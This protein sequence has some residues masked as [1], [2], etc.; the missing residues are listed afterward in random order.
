[1]PALFIGH[2]SPMNGIEVNRFSLAWQ[3]L[4]KTLPR[5]SAV[6]AIS[7]HWLTKGTH[8]HA[9]EC[10]RTI[11]D[12]WGF[13]KELYNISYP[14]PGSP[15]YANATRTL[16]APTT[17]IE[18][19]LEW[20]IDHGTWIVVRRMFPEGDIPVFQLSIDIEKPSQYHFDLGK[21]LASLR[22]KGV[23]IMGSGNL[24]HNLGRV[25][26]EPNAVSY[27]WAL[28]FDARMTDLMEKGDFSSLISY[29]KFGESAKLS[30]PSPDHYWPLLYVLG[31]KQ[32]KDT[33]SF[34]IEGITMG[35]IGMR[36]VLCK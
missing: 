30:V 36:A 1:M 35:S 20:G 7:A 24:V 19:D 25:S 9:S 29:E 8:V 4:G 10:P 12:F 14:C 6:L 28:E 13:P 2:G 5:P 15:T 32:S 33:L 16:L 31:A 26:W 23:L 17:E 22:T 11:Y 21:A 3:D 18:L 34:P 27:D